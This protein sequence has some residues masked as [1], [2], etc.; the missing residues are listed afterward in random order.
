MYA[1]AR[2]TKAGDPPGGVPRRRRRERDPEIATGDS[3]EFR[4][5]GGKLRLGKLRKTAEIEDRFSLSVAGLSSVIR[6][7]CVGF[8]DERGFSALS[9]VARR[10]LPASVNS[11][12]KSDCE[13]KNC[14]SCVTNAC[15]SAEVAAILPMLKSDGA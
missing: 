5:P 13:L 15:S 7:H 8:A 2:L 14:K 3:P 4:E 10:T 9:M 11:T 12:C 1:K 6:D